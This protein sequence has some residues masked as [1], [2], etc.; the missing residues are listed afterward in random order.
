MSCGVRP[1]L[2]VALSLCLFHGL[3]SLCHV[4]IR[5]GNKHEFTLTCQPCAPLIPCTLEASRYPAALSTRFPSP[6]GAASTSSTLAWSWSRCRFLFCPI[7]AMV[8]FGRGFFAGFDA[9]AR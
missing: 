1:T 5:Q 7:L 9:L 2:L 3:N 8:K 6:I 4:A